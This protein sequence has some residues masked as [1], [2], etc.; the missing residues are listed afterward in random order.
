MPSRSTRRRGVSL[1]EVLVALTIFLLAVIVLGNLITTGSNRALDIKLEGQAT[2]LCQSKLAEVVAGV[3]PLSGQADVPFDDE[4][5]WVWSVE[6]E[7]ESQP[8]LWRVKVRVTRQH[9]DERRT[10]CVLTQLVIDPNLRGSTNA[11]AATTTTGT[12][13]SGTN[14]SGTSGTSG[15]GGTGGTTGTGGTGGTGGS[16]KGGN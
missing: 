2:Q 11:P 9:A 4:P 7:Q 8:G 1:L 10:E 12:T 3:V 6:T 5:D 15:T 13:T 14:T 16:T